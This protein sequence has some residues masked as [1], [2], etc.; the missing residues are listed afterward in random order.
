VEGAGEEDIEIRGL[1]ADKP[2]DQDSEQLKKDVQAEEGDWPERGS[3][4]AL[5][6][7]SAV[8][9][10]CNSESSLFDGF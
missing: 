3:L 8:V 6:H 2:D 1:Q 7:Y 10:A 5:R 4:S 9:Y